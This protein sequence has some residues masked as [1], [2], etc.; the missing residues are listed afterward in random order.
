VLWQSH[1]WPRQYSLS[2]LD[3][4]S[5]SMRG[6]VLWSLVCT[7]GPWPSVEGLGRNTTAERPTPWLI[8]IRSSRGCSWNRFRTFGSFEKTGQRPH[9][10]SPG[11]CR[12]A[13]GADECAVRRVC[14]SDVGSAW[15]G[16]ASRFRCEARRP[17]GGPRDVIAVMRPAGQLESIS[18]RFPATGSPTKV[19]GWPRRPL[20]DIDPKGSPIYIK[21]RHGPILQ[22]PGGG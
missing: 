18:S 16:A 13:A 1:E 20:R 10:R 11:S 9:P 8:Q 5:R 14:R 6:P 7:M 22:G 15:S 19:G 3:C 4:E 17:A 12:G 2:P 21:I